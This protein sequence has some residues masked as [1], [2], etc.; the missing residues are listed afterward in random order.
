MPVSYLNPCF[1][2]GIRNNDVDSLSSSGP[3]SL[4]TIVAPFSSG[5][6]INNT[7]YHLFRGLSSFDYSI[8]S[9]RLSF[10]IG[11]NSKGFTSVSF[12]ISSS[13]PSSVVGYT[14]RYMVID[15][16]NFAGS[17]YFSDINFTSIT[18]S[19]GS[20]TYYERVDPPG[21]NIYGNGN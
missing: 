6:T 16:A 2:S 18:M 17:F 4:G 19:S 3:S 12:S 15:I 5:Y 10:H 20:P 8:S 11:V 1:Y 9:N 14:I 21:S 13:Y 7:N